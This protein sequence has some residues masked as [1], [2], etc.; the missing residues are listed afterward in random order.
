MKW[1]KHDSDA[2]T[3]AK[4]KKVKHKYGIVGYGLYFYCIE[5][6]A[7]SIDRQNIT[8]ELEEDAETIALE[9]GLDQLKVQEIMEYMV[10]LRLF[11]NHDGRI[12]CFKLA[13][14]LD[15]TNSKN[16]EIKRIL[17]L[18]NGQKVSDL[19]GD[20]PSDSEI[21]GE[22][23]KDSAQN[24]LD[25]NR[26][27]KNKKTS[28]PP[29]FEI[30]QEMIDWASKQDFSIDL[31]SATDDWKDAMLSDTTKYKYTDWTAAWRNAMKRAQ[32]WANDKNP[33]PTPKRPKPMPKP[34]S[35]S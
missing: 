24:R 26:L 15:D 30:S 17:A 21:V 20:A 31:S 10:G 16:P 27:D 14:R 11:E 22:T 7:M 1:F 32:K 25:K 12:T 4:L 18:L 35:D 13:R 28:L 23:P 5:L 19:V 8:F 6:I 34:G 9:W 29:D 2:H 3:D 33:S